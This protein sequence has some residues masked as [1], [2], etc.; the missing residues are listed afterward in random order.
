MIEIMDDNYRNTKYSNNITPGV[1]I[2]ISTENP[3]ES[4]TIKTTSVEYGRYTTWLD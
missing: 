4:D 1:H 2:L 3:N